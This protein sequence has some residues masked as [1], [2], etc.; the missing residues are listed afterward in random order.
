MF[1]FIL[2]E[3]FIN[4]MLFSFQLEFVNCLS[5]WQW[6]GQYGQLEPNVTYWCEGVACTSLDVLSA[7]HSF[8]T[9]TVITM[10]CVQVFP[11]SPSFSDC[12]IEQMNDFVDDMLPQVGVKQPHYKCCRSFCTVF[13]GSVAEPEPPSLTG[14]GAETIKIFSAP[15]PS[16]ESLL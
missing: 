11:A 15:A 8:S 13:R 9:A 14:A 1:K 10:Y 3:V 6:A 12:N 5:I 16:P 2:F 7:N 4:K